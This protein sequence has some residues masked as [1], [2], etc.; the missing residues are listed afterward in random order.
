MQSWNVLELNTPFFVI[1]VGFAHSRKIETNKKGGK[2]NQWKKGWK[3]Q[4]QQNKKKKKK[5]KK[6]EKIGA[7]YDVRKSHTMMFV[8]GILN[9]TK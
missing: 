7:Y 1:L 2:N 3:K 9:L 4:K 8:L 6:E 5:K